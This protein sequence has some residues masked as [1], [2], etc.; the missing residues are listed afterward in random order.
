MLIIEL[1]PIIAVAAVMVVEKNKSIS[2]REALYLKKA[3]KMMQ[4]LTQQTTISSELLH[5]IS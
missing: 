3:V 2:V 5:L 4:Q 1:T